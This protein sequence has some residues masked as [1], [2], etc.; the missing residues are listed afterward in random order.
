MENTTKPETEM[1]QERTIA[2]IQIE[3]SH[4]AAQLGD[5]LCKLTVL[6]DEAKG[7]KATML[8]LNEEAK[9]L[10]KPE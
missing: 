1:K 7:F 6:E 2:D 3:Y 8:K 4:A 5:R 9:K 10:S